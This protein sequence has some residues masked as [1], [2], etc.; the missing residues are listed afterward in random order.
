LRSAGKNRKRQTIGFY[1]VDTGVG[2]TH[3]SIAAANYAVKEWGVPT[4]VVELGGRPCIH[5]MDEEACTDSFV[6]EDVGFYPQVNPA[7]MP[8]L[9]N[10]RYSCLILDLGH[11]EDTWQEF[12]RCDRKYL[13]ASLSPWRMRQAENFMTEHEYACSNKYFTALLTVT[14]TVY[15]KKRIQ[16]KYH[17]PVRTI[18]LM[19]NPFR[20]ARDQLPFFQALF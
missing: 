11:E 2:T 1:G 16:Q 18:P 19:A 17:V 9:L 20:L 13:V 4:A 14:G 3:L 10:S 7:Q 12:L 8:E 6:Y 5:W 15:E